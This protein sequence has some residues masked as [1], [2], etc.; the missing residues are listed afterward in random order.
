MDITIPSV[1]KSLASAGTAAGELTT[2]WKKS[3]GDSRSLIGELKDNLTYL[4]IVAD[5]AVDLGE[6]IDKI[7]VSAYRRLSSAGFNFNT[8]KKS[9][10]PAYPSL[11]GTDLSSWTGKETEDLVVSIYDKINDLKIRYPHVHKNKNY[12]WNVRVNNIRKRIW[13]L[14]MHVRS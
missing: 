8:L 14:L 13:L 5:D 10:I 4:D 9:R 12:R 3:K 11:E 2:W 1:L 6:V 7:S